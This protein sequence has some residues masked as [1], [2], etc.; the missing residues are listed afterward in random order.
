MKRRKRTLAHSHTRVR[1]N[2]TLVQLSQRADA[3]QRG[4]DTTSCAIALFAWLDN[5]LRRANALFICLMQ[6]ME[7]NIIDIIGVT[8]AFFAYRRQTRRFDPPFA[9]I[10]PVL[11]QMTPPQLPVKKF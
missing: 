7:F 2:R 1:A 10:A 9:Q 3:L 8:Y 5:T 4:E 6:E 11:L